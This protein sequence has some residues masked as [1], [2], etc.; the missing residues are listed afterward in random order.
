M[1]RRLA[2]NTAISNTAT[3]TTTN[4]AHR[5][6]A[7][8]TI[9]SSQA[10]SSPAKDKATTRVTGIPMLARPRVTMAAASQGINSTLLNTSLSSTLA[11]NTAN[12]PMVNS[13]SM[14]NSLRRIPSSNSTEASKTERPSPAMVSTRLG[15]LG[16][17][18]CIPL[19]QRVIVG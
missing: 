10:T 13:N 5:I 2:I 16:S 17:P 9:N 4:T 1:A 12:N 8:T 18:E 6:K 7:I 14:A 15:K 19:R 11:T 3:T